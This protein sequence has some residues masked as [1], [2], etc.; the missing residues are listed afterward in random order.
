MD[1]KRRKN[2]IDASE[3]L[4]VTDI[5]PPFNHHTVLRR[6]NESHSKP[7]ASRHLPGEEGRGR[8]ESRSAHAGGAVGDTEIPTFLSLIHI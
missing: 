7:S 8:S 6:D 1:E 3:V 4:R 2:R 5:I